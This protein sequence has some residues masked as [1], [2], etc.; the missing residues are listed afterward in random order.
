V[1]KAIG[2]AHQYVYGLMG[3]RDA[4]QEIA[5]I[6]EIMEIDLAINTLMG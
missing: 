5:E 1:L 4:R 3:F 6:F 2:L